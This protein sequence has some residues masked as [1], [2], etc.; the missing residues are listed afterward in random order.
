MPL[1]PIMSVLG[2]RLRLAARLDDRYAIVTGV[3]SSLYK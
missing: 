3:P 2:R 1:D